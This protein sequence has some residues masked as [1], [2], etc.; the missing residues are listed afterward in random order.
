MVISKPIRTNKSYAV[1]TIEMSKEKPVTLKEKMKEWCV[2]VPYDYTSAEL[3]EEF[4]ET[5]RRNVEK[6]L[7]D[8]VTHGYIEKKKCRCGCSNLYKSTKPIP[9]A[10]LW[11]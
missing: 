9:E 10:P 3:N 6:N 8:F 11:T 7:K 5:T 1:D 2:N 4:P